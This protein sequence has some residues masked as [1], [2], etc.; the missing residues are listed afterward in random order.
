[1]VGFAC[2]GIA[3]TSCSTA[4]RTPLAGPRAVRRSRL[5]SLGDDDRRAAANAPDPPDRADRLRRLRREARGRPAGRRVVRARRRGG[6]GR[7]DRRARR[8]PTTRPPTRISDDLAIIGTLDFFPPL[9]DDAADVRRD[10]RGE[11]AER[12]VRDGRPGPVRAVDRG[13]PRGPAAGRARGRSSTG[14]ADE[15]PRGRRHARRRPHDPRPRAEVR[16][17]R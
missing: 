3:G 5:S 16:A 13:V 15:G 7:A 12:R 9:V 6:A 17:S 14:A 1:M 8:R 11:R 10:R 4:G 2:S